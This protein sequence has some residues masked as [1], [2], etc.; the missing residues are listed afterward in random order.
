MN[1]RKFLYSAKK[2]SRELRERNLV[3]MLL[4]ACLIFALLILFFYSG[5]ALLAEPGLG[6]KKHLFSVFLCTIFF[7]LS[8]P[9]IF[10][11]N[12]KFSAMI[13]GSLFTC[14]L[15]IVISMVNILLNL[16]TGEGLFWYAIPIVFASF[17]VFPHASFIVAGLGSGVVL[18]LTFNIG[19]LPNLLTLSGFFILAFMSFLAV[20]SM[21]L[22]VQKMGKMVEALNSEIRNRKEAQEE[23]LKD[24]KVKTNFI[25]NVSHEI[26]TPMSAIQG[27]SKYLNEYDSDNL[28]IDQKEGLL[29]IYQ[30]S[31]RLLSLVNEVLDLSK[32]ES[33]KMEVNPTWFSLGNLVKQI[34]KFVNNLVRG[35]DVTLYF[36]LDAALPDK[37]YSDEN[38]IY[39]VLLNIISNSIK[40]TDNGEIIVHIFKQKES[41]FFEIK[42]TGLGISEEQLNYLFEDYIH[43][44][45]VNTGYY[46]SGLGLALCNKLLE[47]MHGKLTIDSKHNQGAVI[48]FYIP[49]EHSV[50]LKEEGV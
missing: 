14:V 25:S 13:S 19:H 33:G 43:E 4:L 17:I 49:I 1:L 45:E 48:Y 37:V 32:L 15:F 42:D 35:K 34:K 39:Q 23:A 12:R 36:Q 18:F 28:T 46:S 2:D 40:F 21:N 22:A 7:I 6:Y 50:P 26:R 47:L 10:W 30:S 44:E 38:K 9:L 29:M 31:Q 24:N 27:I 11:V 8:G 3:Y 41:V 16:F 5:L 20:R